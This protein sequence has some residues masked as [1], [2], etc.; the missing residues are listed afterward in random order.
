MNTLQQSLA[1]LTS[2]GDLGKRTASVSDASIFTATASKSAQP[3]Q[4]QIEVLSL[5]RAQ[6]LGS[7]AFASSSALV[8]AGDMTFTVGSNSFTV[9]ATAT[10]PWRSCATRSQVRAAIVGVGA[11]LVAEDGGTRMVLTARNTGTANAVGV[12]T[13]LTNFSELQSATDSQVKVDGYTRTSAYNYV[14]N[15]V[16]GVSISLN[17]ASVGTKVTVTVAADDSAANTAVNKLRR[18][19]TTRW[20]RP[21]AASPA[22]T[23]PARRPAH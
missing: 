16:D 14:S 9:T 6:K 12:S 8:G 10:T 11:T 18:G 4:T 1:K 23:R 7:D 20:F 5:A 15:V 2:G 21:T 22:T 17:K 3:G 13:S 19:L